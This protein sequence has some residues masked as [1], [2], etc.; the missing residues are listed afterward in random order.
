MKKLDL[1]MREYREVLRLDPQ[2][3]QVYNSIG[4][5]YHAQKKYDEAIETYRKILEI[6]PDYFVV[7]LN[8]GFAFES[9][10]NK[11]DAIKTYK[12]IIA[13]VEQS[14][15]MTGRRMTMTLIPKS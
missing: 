14:A 3:V 8:M 1:A 10:G 2:S 12:E 11:Q 7:Y 9:K 13:K 15:R 5:I 4:G 6:K